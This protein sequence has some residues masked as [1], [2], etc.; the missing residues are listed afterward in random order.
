MSAAVRLRST[1]SRPLSTLSNP[2]SRS[3]TRQDRSLPPSTTRSTLYNTLPHVLTHPC[4][5]LSSFFS[6]F[7]SLLSRHQVPSLL[8]T[9]L[10]IC[11]LLSPSLLLYFAPSSPLST[12]PLARRGR[13]ELVWELEGLRRQGLIATEEQVCWERVKEYYEK[14]GR[15]QGGRRLRVEQV[16]VNLRETNG[17]N[18]IPTSSIGGGGGSNVLTVGGT[19]TTISKSILHKSWKLQNLLEK[20]LLDG[21]IPGNKCLRDPSSSSVDK[22]AIV[23]P[24]KWWESE[25][26]LLGDQD[27]H[28]TLSNPAYSVLE[29]QEQ[30]N[31]TAKAMSLPLTVSGSFVGVGFDRFVRLPHT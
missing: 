5:S 6:Q 30:D 13:G 20:R 28:E 3:P 4:T 26:A 31:S 10:I 16:L 21:S 23:S 18:A 29:L 17:L 7:G 19:G 24:T 12:S 14:T 11:S 2:R 9:A 15:E 1:R 27:V 22:C 8:L 25:Q